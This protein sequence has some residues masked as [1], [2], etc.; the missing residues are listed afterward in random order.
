M[1][2]FFPKVRKFNDWPEVSKRDFLKEYLYTDETIFNFDFYLDMDDLD[3]DSDIIGLLEDN[4]SIY[5]DLMSH[6]YFIESTFSSPFNDFDGND[7]FYLAQF[8][9]IIF[10][11]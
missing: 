7:L 6:K 9:F 11:F 3:F 4:E 2:F 10:F 5:Y 8:N 1:S